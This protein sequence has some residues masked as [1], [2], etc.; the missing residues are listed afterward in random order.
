MPDRHITQTMA[1]QDGREGT[2]GS[3]AAL[4]SRHRTP[5]LIILL[6]A[7]I[8]RIVLAVQF[9]KPAGDERRYTTPAVNML[10]GHGFSSAASEPYTPS[11]ATVA[12]YPIFIAAVYAVFGE[13]NP[14]VRIAQS[15][16]DLLTCLLVAFISFG[17]APAALKN[18]AAILALLI[19]GCLSWF[20]IDWTRYI[21]TETLALFFTCLAIVGAIVALRMGRWVWAFAGAACGMALLTRSDSLLLAFGFVL[22]LA[23]QIVR[24]RKAAFLNLLFFSLA[25]VMV[26]SPWTLRNYV[27]LKKFQPLASEYGFAGAQFMP[28]GYLLWIR[29]WITDESHFKVFQPAFIPGDRSFDPHELP[30]SL[31]DSVAEKEQV[32]RLFGEYDCVGRFTPALDESFRGI[33]YQRIKHSP[34]RFVLYLP[35]MRIAS[36]WLTGFATTNSFHRILRILMVLPILIGGT[37]GFALWAGNRPLTQLLL[38][39]ILTRT[40][41]LG[42][43]YAPESRYIVEAYPAMIAACG[44]TGAALWMAL[45]RNRRA[46]RLDSSTQIT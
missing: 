46:T 28:N 29:T 45:L 33:A 23:L 40:L 18:R 25:I 13:K 1:K 21:L 14:A 41:F 10:A 16:V 20:T 15:L 9:P 27:S 42:Y 24:R 44:V 38:F 17:L 12:A 32:F 19:Y 6:I 35:V 3:F 36:V 11:E 7:A 30:D 5:V 37:L 26:L 22:F 34:V 8:F 31:F 39:I 4:L 2:L 43:H